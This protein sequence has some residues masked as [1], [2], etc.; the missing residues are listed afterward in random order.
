MINCP[1]CDEKFP[2]HLNV[3]HD[4]ESKLIQNYLKQ[5]IEYEAIQRLATVFSIESIKPYKENQILTPTFDYVKALV[6]HLGIEPAIR[7]QGLY[8]HDKQGYA[9]DVF[10]IIYKSITGK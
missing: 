9:Y 10:E 7:S 4:W 2:Y 6:K 1:I 8:V 5:G 3:E